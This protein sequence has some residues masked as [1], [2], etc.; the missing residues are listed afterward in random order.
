MSAG[1]GVGAGSGARQQRRRD[2]GSLPRSRTWRGV[3]NEEESGRRGAAAGEGDEGRG[4][5]CAGEWGGRARVRSPQ[6]VL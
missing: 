2:R 1:D 5:D 4:G 6:G 3:G